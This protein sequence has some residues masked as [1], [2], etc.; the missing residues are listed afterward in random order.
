MVGPKWYDG[1]IH[2]SCLASIITN[3]MSRCVANCTVGLE[4]A[5]MEKFAFDL[6]AFSLMM[7]Q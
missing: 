1:F 4:L 3:S 5:I 2:I 7:C 6:I